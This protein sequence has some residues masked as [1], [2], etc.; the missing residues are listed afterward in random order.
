MD[1]S[2]STTVIVLEDENVHKSA[3]QPQF[4]VQISDKFEYE[5]AYQKQKDKIFQNMEESGAKGKRQKKIS[6][7]KHRGF[8]DLRHLINARKMCFVKTWK[9]DMFFKLYPEEIENQ[10]KLLAEKNRQVLIRKFEVI[11]F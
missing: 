7:S 1:E 3:S 8:Q 2:I 5:I 10:T 9:N 11:S 4:I 6:K